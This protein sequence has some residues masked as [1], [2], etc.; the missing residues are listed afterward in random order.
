MDRLPYAC[1]IADRWLVFRDSRPAERSAAAV[2]A[3][4]C[5]ALTGPGETHAF[6]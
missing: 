1:S 4:R 2:T 3:R 6:P 5:R